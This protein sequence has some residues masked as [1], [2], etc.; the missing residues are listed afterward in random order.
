M[1]PD[2]LDGHIRVCLSLRFRIASWTAP[3]AHLRTSKSLSRVRC[4]PAPWRLPKR[5]A[6][7]QWPVRFSYFRDAQDP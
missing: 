5:P 4:A 2:V 1:I 6:Q 7:V 3:Q